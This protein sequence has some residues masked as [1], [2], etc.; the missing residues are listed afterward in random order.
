MSRDAMRRAFGSGKNG[1][2]NPTVGVVDDGTTSDCA[3]DTHRYI[4]KT[5][6]TAL[7]ILVVFS[8]GKFDD[9][10]PTEY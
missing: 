10:P 6:C 2:T 5:L 7:I 4:L 1:A 9:F 8:N 3:A